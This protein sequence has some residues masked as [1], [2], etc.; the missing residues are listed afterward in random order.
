VDKMTRLGPTVTQSSNII[1]AWQCGLAHFCMSVVGQDVVQ[2]ESTAVHS[3]G[4]LKWHE[5]WST[6]ES[7]KN[8]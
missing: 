8:T 4:R 5:E 7:L 1:P 2:Q 3:E 6:P